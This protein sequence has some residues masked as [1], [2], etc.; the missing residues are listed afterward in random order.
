MDARTFLDNFGTIAEAPGGV[1]RLRELVLLLAV[2]GRLVDQSPMDEPAAE[3]IARASSEL[4]GQP[5]VRGRAA[6]KSTIRGRG[7]LHVGTPAD[8]QVPAGWSFTA[9]SAVTR[10]ESGHTP[11]RS[12]PAYWDG[13]FPWLGITDARQYRNRVVLDTE[14]SI[15][16]AGIDNSATRLLPAGTVCLSRT[17][18]VGYVV[19]L[20]RAMCT[21]Q[22]FVNFICSTAIMPAYLQLVLRSEGDGLRK[23][24]KG[25]VHQ[26]IYFPEVKAFHVL[27][28]PVAEQERIISKVDELILLCDDLEARQQARRRIATRLRASSLDALAHAEADDLCV[29]W[30]RVHTNWES[31]INEIDDV[32]AI[33]QAI[34]QLA[35]KGKLV[36]QRAED[37]PARALV[38]HCA[39][40]RA[41]MVAGGTSRKRPDVAPVGTG[42]FDLPSGWEW[43]RIDD[44]FEVTGGIQKSGKRRP[45]ANSYPYLRVANVQ[46]GRLDLSD[47]ERFELF[48]DELERYRL[49]RGDLLVVEGNGSQ[50]EIGR[51]ARWDGAVEDCVHQNHLIR[52]RPLARNLE[53]FALL[54]LNSP[55]GME[56]MTRLAVTTSGLYNLSVGKIRSIPVP[57]PPSAE[58]QRIV[59]R[60]E[61]LMSHCDR[62]EVALGT[63]TETAGVLATGLTRVVAA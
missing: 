7:A 50:S 36:A 22:D 27:L 8:L 19:V 32:Y 10:L 45:M 17:A 28:P 1:S 20:G 51:C 33:R 61:E 2:T 38:E 15:S 31:L 48:D 46:R 12:V 6:S 57:L 55:A 34:L 54:Y 35:V 30:G 42:Q 63:R 14:K 21:S 44:C 58:Q 53:E 29:A 41:A 16:Q 47:L 49:Q 43:V 56:I 11:D 39:G 37:E 52:C 25:A 4:S 24:S 26:T 13:P 18:S 62:L 9:L 40:A 3:A 23:F 5:S 59:Q 60:V